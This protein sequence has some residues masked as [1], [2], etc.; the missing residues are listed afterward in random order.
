VHP[1]VVA[2][3]N[4]DAHDRRM[5]RMKRALLLL[6][7]LGACSNAGGGPGS[8]HAGTTGSAGATS[9]AGATGSAG[10]TSTAGATGSAGATSTAG[11]GGDAAGSS[12]STGTAG[13]TAGAAGGSTADAAAPS[14]AATTTDA[15]T[16]EA[17]VPHPAWTGTVKIMVLGSSNEESTCWRAFLWQKLRAAGVTNFDFVGRNNAGP[18]CGVPGY[19][20]DSEAHGG[21][22]VENITADAWLTTF[23]ANPPDIILQHNGGADLLNG[24]PYMNVINAYTLS[25]KQV[26]MV[27]PRVV[28]FA[29]QHT[30]QGG[31]ND[32]KPVMD[33]NAAMIP[34]AAGITTPDSPVV[35]VD[36]YTGI[37]QKTD[38]SDGT[39]LNVAGSQKVSDRFLAVLLPLFKN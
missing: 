7:L 30:P 22:V 24:K 37:D 31:P 9:T 3:T 15:A 29:A 27:S 21:T 32:V 23:K 10:A 28:Y 36:L 26:R 34:W 20:K 5:A 16:G 38:T 39:H 4:D 17:G 2:R 19:D 33:L 18:D 12:G 13:A 8:G 1:T 11:A 6:G 25:V 14:D 35:V